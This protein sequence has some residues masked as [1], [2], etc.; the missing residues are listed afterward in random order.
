VESLAELRDYREKFNKELEENVNKPQ[1]IIGFGTCGIAAG[2][3]DILAAVQ[4]EV[5][6]QELD[7]NISQ[8]GCVGLCEKEPLLDVKLPGEDRITYGN[9]SVDDVSKIIKEHVNDGKIVED[10]AIAR[11]EE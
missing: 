2:A 11:L 4:S 8:T 10:L 6:E 5:E 1:I 9:L 7:V 3:K